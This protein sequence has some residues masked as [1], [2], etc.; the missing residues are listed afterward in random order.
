M[1]SVCVWSHVQCS[2]EATYARRL[3]LHTYHTDSCHQRSMHLLCWHSSISLVRYAL[4]VQSQLLSRCQQTPMLIFGRSLDLITGSHPWPA[5]HL[6]K[7]S[8]A[9]GSTGL[10][11]EARPVFASVACAEP[12][13]VACVPASVAVAR[14][15]LGWSGTCPRAS[16]LVL[17]WRSCRDSLFARTCTRYF[18]VCHSSSLY[19]PQ[20]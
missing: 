12:A 14:S 5:R 7:E 17:S 19:V 2:I 20:N 3:F 6:M 15:L 1:R 4:L 10:A 9:A 11:V 18:Y 16:P 8:K 13:A